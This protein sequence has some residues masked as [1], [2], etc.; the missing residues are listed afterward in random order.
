MW[1]PCAEDLLRGFDWQALRVAVAVA[2][3][4]H[5]FKGNY[6]DTTSCVQYVYVTVHHLASFVLRA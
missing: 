3:I 6:C 2:Q 1:W 5:F 4:L